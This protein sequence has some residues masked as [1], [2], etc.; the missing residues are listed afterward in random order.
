MS[1]PCR[2][3]CI[4]VDHTTRP[5]PAGIQA[6]CNWNEWE[7]EEH[8]YWES[9]LLALSSVYSVGI[10]SAAGTASLS[11]SVMGAGARLRGWSEVA[12]S[13][14]GALSVGCRNGDSPLRSPCSLSPSFLSPSLVQMHIHL[15]WSLPF[16]HCDLSLPV[17]LPLCLSL[18]LCFSHSLLPHGPSFLHLN[19]CSSLSF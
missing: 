15:L 19:P 17:S 2:P 3:R 9:K 1:S 16:P 4:T 11:S 6:P 12:R 18:Y 7:R 10:Q 8:A 13:R 14:R 5:C